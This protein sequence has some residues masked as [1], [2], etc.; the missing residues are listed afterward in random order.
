LKSS[1]LKKVVLIGA[2]TGGPILIQKIVASLGTLDGVSVVI[3]QHMA[4]DFI[5]SFA[6]NLKHQSKN[7]IK[8]IK[9]NMEFESNTIYLAQGYSKAIYGAWNLKFKHSKVLEGEFNP[10]INTIFSSFVDFIDNIEILCVVLTGIGDDG[11]D[12]CALLAKKGAMC[13]TQDSKSAVV[14]GMSARARERVEGIKAL[15]FEN[16]KEEIKSFCDV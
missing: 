8:I 16:I 4:E 12:G 11:V 5:P 10:H 3:A 1:I 2:S 14:D 13:I 6:K 15:S 9:D 7:E